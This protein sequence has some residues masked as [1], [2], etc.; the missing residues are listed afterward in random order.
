MLEEEKERKNT[1]FGNIVSNQRNQVTIHRKFKGYVRSKA[2]KKSLQTH[3]KEKLKQRFKLEEE[4]EAERKENPLLKRLFTQIE[5]TKKQET[6]RVKREEIDIKIKDLM[7]GHKVPKDV[8]AAMS[9][10]GSRLKKPQNAG[11]ANKNSSA[12]LLPENTVGENLI[13]L[14]EVEE[15]SL[16]HSVSCE[17]ASCSSR[18]ITYR[19]LKAQCTNNDHLKTHEP[20]RGNSFSSANVV[21]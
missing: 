12:S 6:I 21:K 7:T 5:E 16:E 9:K 1:H 15:K 19:E 20:K 4:N 8:Q 11:H 18:V 3:F 10:G 2:Q 14:V 17:S 13:S